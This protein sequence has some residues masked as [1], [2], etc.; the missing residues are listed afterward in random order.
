MPPPS[1][2]LDQVQPDLYRHYLTH[3]DHGLLTLDNGGLVSALSAGLSDLTGF[4]QD[5][6][7][8]QPLTQLV[9]P[10]GV[11]A[12]QEAVAS[13]LRSGEACQLEIQCRTRDQ[14]VLWCELNLIP[15]AGEEHLA[16]MIT[17]QNVSN[18]RAAQVNAQQVEARHAAIL[19]VSLDAIISIDQSGRVIDWN[20]AAERMF[21]YTAAEATGQPMASLI[22]PE[23]ERT[24]HFEGLRRHQQTGRTRVSGQVVELTALHHDGHTFPVEMSMAPVSWQGETFYTSFIRE[25]TAQRRAHQQ[26][27]AHTEYLQLI[28]SQ[29]PSV[30]W[31]TDL[32]L[33][34][35]S[36]SGGHLGPLEVDLNDFL[37]RSIGDILQGSSAANTGV[38]A[39]QAALAGST[40]AYVLQLG[41]LLYETQVRPFHDPQGHLVGTVA[42]ATDVTERHRQQEIAR[43][44]AYILESIARSAPLQETIEWISRM[45][46]SHIQGIQT[47]I[48]QFEENDLKTLPGS[49][50]PAAVERDFAHF[51]QPALAWSKSPVSTDLRFSTVEQVPDPVCVAALQEAGIAATW[52]MPVKADQGGLAALIVLYRQDRREPPPWAHEIIR[53]A[54]QLLSVALEQQKYLTAILT[55]KEQTL[56]TLGLAL[57]YRDYETKGHTDRVTQLSLELAAALR[58]PAEEQEDLRRGAYLHD[59]GKIAVSDQILLKP[60]RPT[61]EEWALIR[62]HPVTGYEMLKHIPALSQG[63]LEVVLRH[64]EHWNGG[65]YPDGLAGESIPRLARIFAVVDTFDALTSERPYKRAWSVQEALDELQRMSGKVLDPQIVPVFIQLKQ[66]GVWESV[67][68]AE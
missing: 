49:V 33:V 24:R 23:S 34:L 66:P 63:T 52:V 10:H 27:L 4:A 50:V 62:R 67:D 56:R 51:V 15:L 43:H 57:E 29:L 35:Q 9:T 47:H 16:A 60:G 19:N 53:Q 38:Q 65:G 40:G 5:E 41:S 3:H 13:L 18:R 37:G 44:R 8:R 28:Q 11:E 61:E 14:R 30:F 46:E 58:V 26:L 21:G 42:L 68:E 25:L 12:I 59:V 45:L 36:A 6:Y 64:H 1:A 22:I 31:T 20:H 48:L 2:L 17:V 55:T 54:A 39:H 32:N 7:L